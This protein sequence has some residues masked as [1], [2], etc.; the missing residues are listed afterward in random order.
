MRGGLCKPGRCCGGLPQKSGGGV[1]RLR[2]LR[3]LRVLIHGSGGP[4]RDCLQPAALRVSSAG[5]QFVAPHPFIRGTDA[6]WQHGANIFASGQGNGA[7]RDRRRLEQPNSGSGC[8]LISG[9]RRSLVSGSCRSLRL[10]LGGTA[11]APVPSAEAVLAIGAVVLGHSAVRAG[12]EALAAA[13]AFTAAPEA[14][15]VLLPL[16]QL[17]GIVLQDQIRLIL[18]Q[19]TGGNIAVQFFLQAG[20][21]VEFP[22]FRFCLA[23]GFQRFVQGGGL[24]LGGVRRGLRLFGGSFRRISGSGV[25]GGFGGSFSQG[26]HAQAGRDH[27]G[28]YDQNAFLAFHVDDSPFRLL[29]PI[30]NNCIIRENPLKNLE[31]EKVFN[32]I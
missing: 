1:C 6:G 26:R 29:V 31:A 32:L 13:A 17:F 16:G 25:R 5:R 20:Q 19:G 28:Q 14:G 30:G 18:G 22:A 23:V 12:P 9:S 4:D 3:P 11:E 7:A 15:T 21:G 24:S 8:F 2:D 27:E 10:V